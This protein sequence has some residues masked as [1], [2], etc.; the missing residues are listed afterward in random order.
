MATELE[1]KAV[2]TDPPRLRT[3]LAALGARRTFRG[4]L[5]D[6]RLDRDG[7]LAR[8]DEVLRL[9]QWLPEGGGT[10]R[11]VIGW[12]GPTG[13]TPDGYKRRDELEYDAAPGETA[14]ATF[15]AL[16]YRVVHALDRFVELWEYG[17]VV[18]RLEWYPRMDVLVEIEGPPAAMEQVIGALGLERAACRPEA[19]LAFTTRYEARTGRPAIVAEAELAGAAPD[20]NAA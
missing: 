5:R 14:L 1:L 11:A 7:T 2:V 3:R 19:L 13:V 16:G 4:F 8:R 18:V 15:E 6:R 17:G 12:K 10:P 20:W 9:R